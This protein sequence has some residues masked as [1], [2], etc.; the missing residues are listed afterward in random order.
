MQWL[1]KPLYSDNH[2]FFWSMVLKMFFIYEMLMFALNANIVIYLN[3]RCII[4]TLAGFGHI[5]ESVGQR[6]WYRTGCSY[7]GDEVFL[8]TITVA[9][10][11]GPTKWEA[12]WWPQFMFS[13]W[14]GL[15]IEVPTGQYTEKP[16]ITT[17]SLGGPM[18]RVWRPWRLST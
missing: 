10:P 18:S 17:R 16:K 1:V 11:H 12:V 7:D 15:C 5:H 13:T 8:P 14:F 9:G 4:R 2:V 3:L 6:H